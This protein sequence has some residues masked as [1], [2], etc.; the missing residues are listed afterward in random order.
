MGPEGK[1]VGGTTEPCRAHDCFLATVMWLCGGEGGP[2]PAAV[3]VLVV[4]IA[5]D[6]GDEE[7]WEMVSGFTGTSAGN[8]HTH[9]LVIN[10]FMVEL[11]PTFGVKTFEATEGIQWGV[12]L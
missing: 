2:G 4:I 6:D 1:E 11:K 12:I 7:V 9:T 10:I 3:G 5:G 8:T